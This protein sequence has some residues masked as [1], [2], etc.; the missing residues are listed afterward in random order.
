MSWRALARG[1]AL[2]TIERAVDDA[3]RLLLEGRSKMDTVIA[4]GDRDFATALDLEAERL[5]RTRLERLSADIPFL[6]EEWGGPAPS[7]GPIWIL[8]PIDGTVN[9][10][11]GSPLCAISLALVE[12]GR[13]RLA[14][15]DFPFLAERYVAAEGVGAYLNG[16]P[17]ETIERPLAD[18][19]IGFTDFS[20]GHDAP[21]E[22]SV[23]LRLMAALAVTALRVRVHGSE[24]LELAWLAAG[25]L[26]AAIML[27]NLPWDVSGG[28]LLVREAGGVV[29]DLDG[30]EHGL[31]SAATIASTP[32]LKRPLLEVLQTALGPGESLDLLRRESPQRG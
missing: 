14:I 29:Y 18:A 17:I 1:P 31:T 25:R 3:S 7:S 4:K 19:V 15:V 9:F 22:N 6:G 10:A 2:L 13:P 5:I 11:R 32:A 30:A 26:D 20:V 21:T 27:S 8:D 23:H 24:A 12:G 28:V 16:A